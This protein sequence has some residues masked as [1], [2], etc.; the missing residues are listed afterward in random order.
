MNR[1]S[2][3]FGVV[4]QRG[5]FFC[6]EIHLCGQLRTLSEGTERSPV[7]GFGRGPAATDDAVQ[8]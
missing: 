6:G 5:P 2:H 8:Q 3:A 7:A 4:N 1:A